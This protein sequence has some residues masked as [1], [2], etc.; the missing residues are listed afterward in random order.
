MYCRFEYRCATQRTALL[1]IIALT[2]IF[3][4]RFPSPFLTSA[5]VTCQQVLRVR[6]GSDR[7]MRSERRLSE[8]A[9]IGRL[10]MD[11]RFRT[12]AMQPR[13]LPMK[14]CRKISV[15]CEFILNSCFFHN[16]PPYTSMVALGVA[17]LTTLPIATSC[18]GEACPC[19]FGD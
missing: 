8:E 15:P 4:F 10:A 1:N 13:T 5:I 19:R 6:G 16:C 2:A 17:S 18:G 11:T 7:R 3:P 12:R 9:T 14:P